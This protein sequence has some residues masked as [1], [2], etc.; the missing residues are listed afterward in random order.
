MMTNTDEEPVILLIAP[1][2][3][4]GAMIM[5][6]AYQRRDTCDVPFPV[7]QYTLA[8]FNLPSPLARKQVTTDKQAE[9]CVLIHKFTG[10]AR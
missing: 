5:S 7:F 4:D 9:A 6:R 3:C 8:F 10:S 1:A 2:D